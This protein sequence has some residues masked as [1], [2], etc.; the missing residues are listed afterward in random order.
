VN[1][2]PPATTLAIPADFVRQLM[3]G[4]GLQ[5]REVGLAAMVER[6]KRHA[7]DAEADQLP[8]VSAA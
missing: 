8:V 7:R 3:A 5:T 2:H 6:L 4:L 1:D